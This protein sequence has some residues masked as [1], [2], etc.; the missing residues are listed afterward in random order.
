[1][2]EEGQGELGDTGDKLS[3]LLQI[4][5]IDELSW[6]L[7]SPTLGSNRES[8]WAGQTLGLGEA[9]VLY[10]DTSSIR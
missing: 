3:S 1:M 9:S 6:A 5:W 2:K 8:T 7:L 4:P 10:L